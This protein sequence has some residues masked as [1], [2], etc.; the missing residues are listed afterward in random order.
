MDF[1]TRINK[2]VVYSSVMWVCYLC[3]W[4]LLCQISKKF[5]Y[6]FNVF[7]LLPS[8]I[9]WIIKQPKSLVI[10]SFKSVSLALNELLLL[11]SS[12]SDLPAASPDWLTIA[13]APTSKPQ[14]LHNFQRSL[15]GDLPL[16]LVNFAK[17]Y[18][19]V[20]TKHF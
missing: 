13:L 14:Q 3:Q 4:P 17:T 2:L 8:S 19:H 5:K 9:C 7:I 11:T 15:S 1:S 20:N 10:N 12:E 6:S 16:I 18:H